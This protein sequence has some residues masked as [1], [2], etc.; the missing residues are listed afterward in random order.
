M[1]CICIA[2]IMAL[3]SIV[4]FALEPLVSEIVFFAKI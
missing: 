4:V 2:A 1:G 3:D